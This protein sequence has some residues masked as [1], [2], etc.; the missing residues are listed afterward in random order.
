MF[1]TGGL[2]R[3]LEL[4]IGAFFTFHGLNGFLHWFAIPGQSPAFERFIQALIE[5]R[6]IMP[7]V[8]VIEIVAGILLVMGFWSLLATAML[9][10]LVFVIVGAHLILNPEKGWKMALITGLPY[11]ALLYSQG[12]QWTALLH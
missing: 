11:F 3:I 7:V 12:I 9:A 5:A 8:K 10:P 1:I 2:E 6:F 4:L